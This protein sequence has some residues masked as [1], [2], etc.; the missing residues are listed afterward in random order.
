M[1][2]LRLAL[3]D[4]NVESF[5]TADAEEPRGTVEG[6]GTL[7]EKTCDMSCDI[8]CWTKCEDTCGQTENTCQGQFSCPAGCETQAP[9]NT[10]WNTCN[11]WHYTC[12]NATGCPYCM[13]E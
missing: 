3:E 6:H 9:Q 11:P 2:K 8:S 7:V 5:S 10:C 13:T 12:A 4:L 1:K